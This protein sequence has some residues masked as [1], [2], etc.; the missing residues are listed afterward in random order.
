MR[1]SNGFV[2]LSHICPFVDNKLTRTEIKFT[3][4]RSIHTHTYQQV[5]KRYH[6][7]TSHKKQ[8]VSHRIDQSIHILISRYQKGIT[9]S[10]YTGSHL[11]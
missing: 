6:C 1:V 11:S 7:F 3:P 4:D 5:S 10:L 9:A 8:S 2:C